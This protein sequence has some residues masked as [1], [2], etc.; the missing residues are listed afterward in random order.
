MNISHEM[1]GSGLF[2]PVFFILLLR[3][4]IIDYTHTSFINVPL[5]SLENDR[6]PIPPL[7]NM[8]GP[9]QNKLKR[10]ACSEKYKYIHCHP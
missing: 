4:A 8:S 10:S 2:L 6:E 3:M 1:A 5:E 9:Q 7:S